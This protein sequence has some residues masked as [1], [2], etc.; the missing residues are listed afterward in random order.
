MVGVIITT[1]INQTVNAFD[2]SKNVIFFSNQL[3]INE[4]AKKTASRG[5]I[6]NLLCHLWVFTKLL[7]LHDYTQTDQN[8]S[9]KWS[10][11]TTTQVLVNRTL[12]Y[13]V[14]CSFMKRKPHHTTPIYYLF[15]YFILN[16][17]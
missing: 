6:L 2:V 5:L 1:V 9:Q 17:Y 15:I 11:C 16:I 12:V 3:L 7:K 14:V 4:G 10:N 8:H 13:S